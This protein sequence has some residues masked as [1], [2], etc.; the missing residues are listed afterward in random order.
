VVSAAAAAG[1]DGGALQLSSLSLLQSAFSHWGFAKDYEPHKDGFFR[2]AVGVKRL[3]G[4][5][6]VTH[7]PND[8]AVGLAYPIASRLRQQ[9]ASAIGDQNDPYGGI[10]RNGALKTPE[11]DVTHGVLLDINASYAGLVAG[12]ICNLESSKFIKAHSDVH[13]PQ[14]AHAIL[15]AVEA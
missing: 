14:V 9:V 13:G 3:K 5:M 7:T 11:V 6:M 15:S 12:R 10:G 8:K 2:A 4:P 1:D